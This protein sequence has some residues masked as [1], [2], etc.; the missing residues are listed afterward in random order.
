MEEN[1]AESVDTTEGS[2]L[3]V[4]IPIKWVLLLLMIICPSTAHLLI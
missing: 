1:Q 4:R 2:E 3:I